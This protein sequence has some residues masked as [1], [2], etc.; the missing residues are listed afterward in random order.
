[1]S[2]LKRLKRDGWYKVSQKGSHAQFKHAVKKGRV[3]LP[4]HLSVL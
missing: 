4:M 2:F 1:M 3:T